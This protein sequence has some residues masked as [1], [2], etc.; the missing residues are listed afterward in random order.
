VVGAGGGVDG[1]VVLS[2][3][4][5][6][7]PGEPVIWLPGGVAPAGIDDSYLALDS[8]VGEQ[9]LTPSL[10]DTLGARERPIT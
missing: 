4:A 3:A 7:S 1:N 5:W 10:L 9:P 8:G 6:E 2:A